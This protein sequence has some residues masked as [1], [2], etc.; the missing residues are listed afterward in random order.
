[1]TGLHFEDPVNFLIDE[2]TKIPAARPNTY[3]VKLQYYRPQRPN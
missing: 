3:Y 2:L 1:M